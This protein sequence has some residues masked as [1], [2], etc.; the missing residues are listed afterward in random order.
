MTLAAPCSAR[1]DGAAPPNMDA[2]REHFE[3]ARALYAQG[4]YRDAIR[5][6]E[7]AHAFDPLAKDLVFN[8]GIVNEKLADIDR[9]LDWFHTYE[10]LSLTPQERERAS[11]VIRRLEGA[12]HEVLAVT[13]NPPRAPEKAVSAT[14]NSHPAPRADGPPRGR[15]DALTIGA[16]GLSATALTVGVVM[17]VSALNDCVTSDFVI[18]PA[19]QGGPNLRGC[20]EPGTRR[21]FGGGRRRRRVRRS[22]RVGAGHGL[23]LL[24][25][26]SRCARSRRAV[27]GALGGTGPWRWWGEFAGGLLVDP[28]PLGIAGRAV[29]LAL[30]LPL[31]GVVAV[32]AT[33]ACEA[34]VTDSL[35]ILPCQA[36]DDTP[37]ETCPSGQTCGDAGWCVALA[38]CDDSGGAC[39]ADGASG[40]SGDAGGDSARVAPTEGGLDAIADGPD[41]SLGDGFRRSRRR[42]QRR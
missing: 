2:A 7:A 18:R 3:S 24:R 31:G 33:A 36:D 13:P 16:A 14:P 27:S 6:L 23:P 41:N 30:G 42:R 15:I 29:L 26:T 39:P 19:S 34:I 8:L 12:K 40:G 9:A 22:V 21:P 32:V 1:A 11:A 5:E 20:S 35:P 37:S 28:P 10:T 17:S 25:S 4:A 38:V